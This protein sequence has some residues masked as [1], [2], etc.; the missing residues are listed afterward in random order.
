MIFL[1]RI[2]K[3]I[4]ENKFIFIALIVLI[5]VNLILSLRPQNVVKPEVPIQ[6]DTIIPAGFVLLPI[7]LANIE[8]IKGLIQHFGVID[9]YVAATPTTP[10]R[11]IASRIKILRAPLNENEF[12]VL[13]P[14]NLSENIMKTNGY[15]TGVVQ[16]R[17]VEGTTKLAETKKSSPIQIEYNPEGN[18]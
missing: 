18:L 13:V 14:E 17:F 4:L 7:T 3:S 10:G 5:I 2:K 11:K 16:N 6:A 1:D 15:F 9:L 12:A 8:S